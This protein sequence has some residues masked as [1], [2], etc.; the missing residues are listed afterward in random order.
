M[1]VCVCALGARTRVCIYVHI[2]IHEQMICNRYTKIVHLNAESSN[3][4]LCGADLPLF[5]FWD[6][7]FK[8]RRGHGCLSFEF[9][10]L[11]GTDLCDGPITCIEE[12]YRV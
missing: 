1:C 6:C 12:S 7:G 9:S 5:A 11:S 3:R 8:S 2:H 10:V 4:T